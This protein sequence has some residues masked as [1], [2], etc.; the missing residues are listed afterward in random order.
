[1]TQG[2]SIFCFFKKKPQE[3]SK[4]GIT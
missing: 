4:H 1:L 3:G 2:G